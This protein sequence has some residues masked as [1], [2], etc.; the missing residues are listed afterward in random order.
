MGDL[1]AHSHVCQV[2]KLRAS[3]LP[4]LRAEFTEIVDSWCDSWQ[5]GKKAP[6]LA[7]VS[8]LKGMYIVRDTRECAIEELYVPEDEE[9]ELL[10]SLM[11][12]RRRS[13]VPD[14]FEHSLHNL[15]RR[16]FVVEHE[17][18]LISLVTAPDARCGL[19]VHLMF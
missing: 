3:P 5:T 7:K 11:T 4:P 9:Y 16:N 15:L 17:E 1:L 6:V 19:Q 13:D 2:N 12:P 18:H 10:D 8:V 14:R